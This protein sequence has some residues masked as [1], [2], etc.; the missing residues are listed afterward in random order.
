MMDKNTIR[1]RAARI[2]LDTDDEQTYHNRMKA[3]L[4]ELQAKKQYKSFAKLAKAIGLIYGICD[5]QPRLITKQHGWREE[6]MSTEP[7]QQEDKPLKLTPNQAVGF[8]QNIAHTKCGL[9]G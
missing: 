6:I 2:G 5:A 9:G 8:L 4:I 7:A 3:L 1:N